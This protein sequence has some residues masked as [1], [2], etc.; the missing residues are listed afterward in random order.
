MLAPVGSL[1]ASVVR[2]SGTGFADALRSARSGSPAALLPARGQ[3]ASLHAAPRSS[4]AAE[5]P[6]LEGFGRAA[7][8][9]GAAP[10]APAAAGE[11]AAQRARQL[12][13]GLDEQSRRLDAALASARRGRTFSAAELLALQGQAHRLAQTVEVAAKVVESGAQSIRQAV[14]AQA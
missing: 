2:A 3:K 9:A 12:L 5:P 7:G 4:G 11:G 14:H 10:H 1:T 13:Q 6:G 8:A